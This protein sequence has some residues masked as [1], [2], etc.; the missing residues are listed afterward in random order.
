MAIKNEWRR[1]FQTTKLL[2]FLKLK[3]KLKLPKKVFR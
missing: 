1:N 2:H 3:Q